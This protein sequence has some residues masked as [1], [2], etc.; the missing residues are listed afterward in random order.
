VTPA[1]QA[2]SEVERVIEGLKRR[3]QAEGFRLRQIEER[4]GQ[5]PAYLRQVLSGKIELRYEHVAGILAAIK[6][7]PMDFFTD[8]YG[9]A[10]FGRGEHPPSFD[11]SLALV[12]WSSLREIIRELAEK[13][14]FTKEE[15]DR[16]LKR[17]ESEPP[18]P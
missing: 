17:L 9:P 13:G 7:K 6:V 10:D 5:N 4:L 18:Q 3:I 14:V 8:V 16:L 15:A 11:Y 2:K 1:Q 12:F